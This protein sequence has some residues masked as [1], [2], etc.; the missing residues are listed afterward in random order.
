MLR[1]LPYRNM[2]MIFA[3]RRIVDFC[4]ATIFS[5]A[6][7]KTRS[8]SYDRINEIMSFTASMLHMKNKESTMVSVNQPITSVWVYI[9]CIIIMVE[10]ANPSNIIRIRPTIMIIPER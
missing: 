7:A 8:L 4:S 1:M 10:A 5:L 2:R 9:S 6:D 3:I